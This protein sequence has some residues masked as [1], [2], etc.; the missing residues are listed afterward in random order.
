[1]IQAWQKRLLNNKV[2]VRVEKFLAGVYNE[3]LPVGD[4]RITLIGG[5]GG[6]VG[7]QSRAGT[8]NYAQGGVGGTLQ[9]LLSL[10]E[11][12]DI[13]ITVGGGAIPDTGLY[14]AAGFELEAGTGGTTSITGIPN[15][16]LVANGGT[17]AKFVSYSAGGGTRTVGVMGSTQVSGVKRV[18]INNDIDIKSTSGDFF[19]PSTTR[20][21]TGRA[22]T[23]YAPDTTNGRGGDCGWQTSTSSLG[24]IVSVIGGTGYVLIETV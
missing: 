23:N 22:N 1:M 4:Y 13:S 2:I 18:L 8:F 16:T 9:V 24:T 12:T 17:G 19:I 11:P 20:Q 14:S 5:G 21:P 10:T 7:G 15:T 6:G 3:R